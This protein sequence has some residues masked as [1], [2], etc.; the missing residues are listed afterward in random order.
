MKVWIL[1]TGEPLSIDNG[2]SRGMRAINLAQSLIDRKHEV[3]LWSARFNHTTK[4]HRINSESKVKDKNGLE[5]RLLDSPGYKSNLG[6]RRLIDHLVLGW[7]LR[8]ELRK[9]IP[10]DV[11]FIGYPP[12]EP[13]FVLSKWLY[14]KNIPTMVDIK[15]AWP[16]IFFRAIPSKYKFLGKILLS[17]YQLMFKKI[18]QKS[19]CISS[20]SPK[21][22]AWALAQANREE[23]AFDRV[24]YLTNEPMTLNSEQSNEGMIY[25]EK[26]GL[27]KTSKLV[28]TYIGSLT[29]ILDFEQIIKVANN[30]LIDLVIAGEGPML[31]ELRR[32]CRNNKNIYLPG[33]IESTKFGT[34]MNIS[35]VMLAP[36]IISEDFEMSLPNKFIDAMA[37]GKPMVTSLNGYAREILEDMGIGLHFSLYDANA[38][39]MV[40]RKFYQNRDT[41]IEMS[42]RAKEVYAKR[43]NQKIVYENLVKSLEELSKHDNSLLQS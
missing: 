30:D 39:E 2:N 42:Q 19:T 35:D 17:P 15:D 32:R 5:T 9:E 26:I 6:I 43:F 1:Q 4:K 16:E 38:F 25:W 23:N 21:F 12:I 31:D 8:K 36:Y 10:P 34:L 3:I 11:A 37:Y 27:V 18:L 22:L 14:K 41:L 20:I 7:N 33:W 13:A 29:N 28:C 24:S 40:I